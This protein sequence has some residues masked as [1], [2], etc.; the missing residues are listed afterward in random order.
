[1][2]TGESG[3]V[4][5][6]DKDGTVK[7]VKEDSSLIKEMVKANES[8]TTLVDNGKGSFTYYNESDYGADGKLLPTATGTV[9]NANTL[10]VS[11]DK[12]IYTFTDK[13]GTELAQ[14]DTNAGA[15]TFNDNTTQLG[16]TNVQGAIEKLLEKITTV[17]GTK[18][19]LTGEG[20]VVSDTQG[21]IL[22]DVVLSIGKGAI[23]T[24]KLADGAVTP[25]SECMITISEC[26]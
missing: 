5:V 4:L 14:I 20:I 1:I 16:V 17:E 24:D 23:T 26:V 18:G 15:I 7:W 8:I 13:S 6:T 9:F 19:N 21:V 10:T 25:V 2:E 12:G 3:S 22:K 11:L